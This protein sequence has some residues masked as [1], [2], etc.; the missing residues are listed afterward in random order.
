M[1]YKKKSQITPQVIHIKIN[2]I[3]AKKARR[4]ILLSEM[5]LLK[6]NKII[7]NYRLLRIQELENK[8]KIYKK[9][10]GIKKDLTRLQKL[11]P[12]PK[13]PK[14]IEKNYILEK[15]NQEIEEIQ[16]PSLPK[17]ERTTI[18]QELAEIQRKLKALQ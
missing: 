16:Q 17:I 5:S 1:A 10:I 8:Q 13:I 15:T 14:L 12:M 18:E 7:K 11:M 3:E 6:L 9:M 4:E 2:Y